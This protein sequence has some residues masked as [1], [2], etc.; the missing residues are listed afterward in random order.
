G[1]KVADVVEVDAVVPVG[2]EASVLALIGGGYRGQHIVASGQVG[3]GEGATQVW[4]AEPLSLRIGLGGGVV[5]VEAEQRVLGL[6]VRFDVVGIFG[7]GLLGGL[8][9]LGGTG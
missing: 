1:G 2:A 8:Q 4:N 3:G 6:G 7:G 5:A 9:S